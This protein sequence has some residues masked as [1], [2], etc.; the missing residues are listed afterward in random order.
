[1]TTLSQLMGRYQ[2]MQELG[3]GGM[4]M[5]YEGH[6]NLLN[7]QVAIKVLSEARNIRLGS[8]GRS[9]LLH[10]AQAAA[11]LNHPNIVDIYDAGEDQRVSFIVMELV[12]GRSLHEHKPK[13]IDEIISI[14]CQIC[15]ALDHAHTH[16]IV[17]RDLK[18]ENVLVTPDGTAKLTDF[19][20]ARSVASHISLDGMI[21]GTV[22]YLA[23][24]A[25]LRQSYDGRAD[26]Y[27]MGVMLYELTTGLLPFTADDPLAVISQHLYAPLVPPR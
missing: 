13:S 4:G 22:Y 21:V 10:E 25:A 9:R 3:K 24:E 2:L 11:G 15:A 1:M 27:S 20:L 5:V 18:P 26:L 12:K 8:E 7:R 16:G 6:D 17:H 23:P 19:G 14:A